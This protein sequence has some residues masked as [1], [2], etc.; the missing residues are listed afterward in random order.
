MNWGRLFACLRIGVLVTT[1]SVHSAA[2][3]SSFT[4]SEE[5]EFPHTVVGL[6][7]AAYFDAFN[8]GNNEV[9]RAF[10]EEY[11]SPA[12]LGRHPLEEL[13][14]SYERLRGI[15][16]QM[17]TLRVALSMELQITLLA[18]ASGTDNVLV[19]RFQQESQPPH[20]LGHI[21]FTGID[22]SDVP[23]EYVDYVATRAAR[24]DDSLRVKT[25]N[26]VAELLRN[27]YVYPDLGVEIAEALLQNLAE[28]RYDDATKAGTLA[29]VLTEDAVA[30]SNDR[31]I[32]VDA[33]NP[34]LQESSDPVNRPVEELRRD[35]YGFRDIEVLP[36]NIGFIKF[37][38]IHDD[39]EALDIAAAALDSLALCDALIFDIRDN[40]GG[41]WG[42]ANL[43]LGYLLPSGTVFG[44][45]YDRGGHRVEERA[46]PDS[47]PGRPFDTDVPVYVL[48]SAHTGS[49][50]EGFAYTLKN[51]DRATIVGEVTLGMAHPSKDIVVNDYFRVSIPY[52]RSENIVT[53]TGFEGTGVIPQI[54]VTADR[55]LE[56][57]IE[58]ALQRLRNRD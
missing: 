31:H 35:N 37:D 56:A 32:W 18:D 28:G 25:I 26:A 5:V 27:T 51:F 40:I 44:Y 6:C 12:Y 3:G 24:I 48:T 38:M 50:A 22:H 49:A 19:I 11:R 21:T 47:I 58:D 4:A 45:M 54:R 41:E 14:S 1:F 33:Q 15:F 7:A 39:K 52:L 10:L 23:V 8:S 17:T 13:L 16:G 53:G 2:G 20:Y 30:I 43:F 9:M 34:M 29:D 57:A 46:T 36:G 55:A 42:T